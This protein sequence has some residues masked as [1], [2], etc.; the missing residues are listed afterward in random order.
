MIDTVLALIDDVL[1]AC[2][3]RRGQYLIPPEF[4]LLALSIQRL[5][6]SRIVT[7]IPDSK[8]LLS[9]RHA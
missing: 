6:T 5:Y 4:S 7:Q 1:T 2:P 8:T 9:D 3:A